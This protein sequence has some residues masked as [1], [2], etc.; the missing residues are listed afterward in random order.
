M[1]TYPQFPVPVEEYIEETRWPDVV[2]EF[3]GLYRQVRALASRSL[4]R[5][6]LR[7]QN[8]LPYERE[9]LEAFFR[10]EKGR[11][12][13]F[14]YLSFA[15]LLSQSFGYE[16]FDGV[17]WVAQEPNLA[18]NP[19]FEEGNRGWK[20]DNGK[21]AVVQDATNARTG[22]WCAKTSVP[23]GASDALRNL[24]RIPVAPGDVIAVDGWIKSSADADGQAG[25][26][27]VFYVPDLS[28]EATAANA[29]VDFGYLSPST[30]YVHHQR[31]FVAPPKA[32]YVD[33]EFEV[34]NHNAG[35]WFADDISIRKIEADYIPVQWDPTNNRHID[36]AGVSIVTESDGNR[37]LRIVHSPGYLRG[38]VWR[39][40]FPVFSGEELFFEL[41]GRSSVSQTNN[42]V[43]LLV[44]F[45]PE[46]TGSA[47][48]ESVSVVPN[49]EWTHTAITR[50][51][52][53]GNR[54]VGRAAC[55]LP[56]TNTGTDTYDVDKLAVRRSIPC[57]FAQDSLRF[58]A[59]SAGYWDTEIELEEAP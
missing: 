21:I 31:V 36:P 11:Q 2:V 26:R 14:R 18:Y 23:V 42:Y 35:T 7:Y 10:A 56:Q 49:M 54:W 43:T 27:M 51:A 39:R 16:E 12:N 19:G 15:N 5:V 34:I 22:S 55:W 50:I 47:Q 20:S 57:R 53:S 8:L 32:R 28:E 41:V 46:G 1:D 30:A 59:S 52:P 3:E 24:R 40:W 9:V 6:R 45:W 58:E 25:I 33:V 29:L 17:L 13:R 48:D 38:I 44:R 37:V 4:R